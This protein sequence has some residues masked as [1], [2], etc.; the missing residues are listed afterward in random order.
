M[1][2][3][4]NFD[5]IEQKLQEQNEIIGLLDEQSNNQEVQMQKLQNEQINLSS[6]LL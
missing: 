5:Q 3:F 1:S 4:T 6:E 2:T